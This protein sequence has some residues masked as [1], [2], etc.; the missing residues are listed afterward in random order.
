[1]R[2]KVD[3]GLCIGSANCVAVAPDVFEL[4]NK[5]LSEVK[6]PTAG[7]DDLLQEAAEECPAQAII[8]EDDDGNQI[9][10]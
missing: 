9:Y 5:G 1:M 10:P 3:Q 7:T 6:D 8:L 4:N 2:A